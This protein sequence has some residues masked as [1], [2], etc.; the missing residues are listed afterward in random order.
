MRGDLPHEFDRDDAALAELLRA[1]RSDRPEFSEGLQARIIGLAVASS[2]E[3]AKPPV[4][5][6]VGAYRQIIS[7]TAIAASLLL[8]IGGAA[9]VWQIARR[10]ANRRPSQGI[11][12][13]QTDIATPVLGNAHSSRPVDSRAAAG[14]DGR[15]SLD[16][17]DQTATTA[18]RLSST[19]SPSTCRPTI[20][21]S[22]RATDSAPRSGIRRNSVSR[23][24]AAIRIP[25]SCQ[26]AG[27]L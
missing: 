27:R 5:R 12:A 24:T 26:A 8:V 15:F 9:A 11:I 3:S 6:R 22:R 19:S 13:R 10:A 2:G 16:D 20:G 1:A 21:I 4:R 23:I 14:S 25:A 17:L 18:A 7:W